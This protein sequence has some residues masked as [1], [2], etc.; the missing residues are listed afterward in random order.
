MVQSL[1]QFRQLE[2][3]LVTVYMFSHLEKNSGTL[4]SCTRKQSNNDSESKKSIEKTPAVSVVT[5]VRVARVSMDVCIIAS[6]RSASLLHCS[7]VDLSRPACRVLHLAGQPVQC[8]QGTGLLP[9]QKVNKVVCVCCWLYSVCQSTSVVLVYRLSS[10]G[11]TSCLHK[12]E[13]CVCCR[14]KYMYI[15]YHRSDSVVTRK[16]SQFSVVS[17]CICVRFIRVGFW[18][19]RMCVDLHSR[20]P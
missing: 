3:R 19:E 9:F 8:Y 14:Y 2:M 10:V 6:R 4:L 7:P 17:I 11:F 16:L 20:G 12:F 13:Y 5:H 1:E 18:F 15:T